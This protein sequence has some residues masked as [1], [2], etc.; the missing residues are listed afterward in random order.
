MF[1][2]KLFFPIWM[3]VFT[4]DF[5]QA[6]TDTLEVNEFVL[7]KDVIEREPID[8]VQSFSESDERGWVFAR[9]RNT[10][11]FQ[12]LTF[13]WF[14]NDVIY[15]EIETKIGNSENWRTYS[16]VALQQGFWKVQ[17]LTEADSVLREIRFNVSE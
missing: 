2:L 16:N 12:N 15:S 5:V 6:Q 11:G 1:L 13:L 10:D 17:L 3:L 8:V 4:V 9:I 7:C 14:H